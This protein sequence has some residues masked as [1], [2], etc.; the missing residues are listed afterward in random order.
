MMKIKLAR[1]FPV[2]WIFKRAAT[3]KWNW[4]PNGPTV[5]QGKSEE[6]TGLET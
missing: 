2:I 4:N 5:P 6:V 3:E 1:D